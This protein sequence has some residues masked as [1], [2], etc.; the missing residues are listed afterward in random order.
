MMKRLVVFLLLLAFAAA[1]IHADW[2]PWTKSRDFQGIEF[3]VEN[4]GPTYDK[5]NT[6]WGVQFRNLYRETVIFN[7]EVK[8]TDVS[9]VTTTN[10]VSLG[11]GQTSS[12]M[13]DFYLKSNSRVFVYVDKVRFGKDD[14]KPYAKPDR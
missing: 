6:K 4:R 2:G 10:R 7:F 14:L 9:S 11:T 1:A 12:S 5:K 8:D 3:R 13:R